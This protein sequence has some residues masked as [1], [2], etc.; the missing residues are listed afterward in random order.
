MKKILCAAACVLGVLF[1]FTACRA[2]ILI[3]PSTAEETTL[4]V[5]YTIEGVA[6]DITMNALTLLT[7][8]GS[9]YL[10]GTEGVEIEQSDF[11]YEIGCRVRLT[12]TG[13][14]DSTALQQELAQV[15]KMIVLEAPPAEE[16]MGN[17]VT[18]A[19][20]QAQ[21]PLR[22]LIDSMTLEEKVGQLFMVRCPVENAAALAQQYALGG[23]ILF[24][25]DFQN[26]TPETAAAKIQSFQ[27]VSKIKMLIGVDEEG[28]SVSRISCFPAFRAAPFSAPRLLYKLGG[29]ELITTETQEKAA[30]LKSLGVNVNFAPVC[31][32]STNP[33]DFIYKRS[34][35]LGAEETSAFVRA[36]V[37]THGQAGVGCVLKHFPGYGSNADTHFDVAH[38]ERPLE[39]FRGVDFL[40]FRAG[41]EAGAPCVL[42][43]HNIMTAV[44]GESPASLSPA[45]HT[46]L[47]EELGF[48]GVVITDD[49]AMGAIQKY[50]S[51]QNAAVMAVKAG[52]DMLICTNF[53][54]Q[55]PGVIAAV[56]SGELTEERVDQSVLRILRWKT[57]LGLI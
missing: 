24:S 53:A 16:A 17:Q 25:R 36:S 54:Q 8:D 50:T 48:D 38:D 7:E 28:G 14:L 37:E 52:N 4:P 15:V 26:E 42:V 32:V 47:R 22:D 27:D 51:D 44:D 40:P 12:Y 56:Q 1:V 10:F 2:D 13:E 31:D 23:Y 5:E 20:T 3:E 33:A 30:L 41:I 39:A 29:L 35:G 18:E 45:V 43:S 46:L 49:L 9:S 57:Q 34:L 19:E 6:Q 11:P 55:I 21:N